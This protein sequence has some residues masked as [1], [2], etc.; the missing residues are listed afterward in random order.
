[1]GKSSVRDALG[2]AHSYLAISGAWNQTSGLRGPCLG[3]SIAPLS[4]DLAHVL[5]LGVSFPLADYGPVLW[6]AEPGRCQEK[7]R[8]WRAPRWPRDRPWR[9]RNL[10][11]RA[12]PFP[13][14]KG[15]QIALLG[16]RPAGRSAWE[17]AP[18]R[19]SEPPEDGE[20]ASACFCSHQLEGLP[21]TYCHGLPEPSL[22]ALH[23]LAEVLISK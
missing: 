6:P 17:A 3:P 7:C 23:H 5:L 8:Q 19:A 4:S 16:S 10:H 11:V 14:E 13:A 9:S 21:P 22:A 20:E 2:G 1:M 12:Q 18:V 15:C